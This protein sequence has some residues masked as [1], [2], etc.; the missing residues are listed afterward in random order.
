MNKKVLAVDD[1]LVN[2]KLLERI[3]KDYTVYIETNSLAVPFLMEE[4]DPD[5]VL[6]DTQMPVLNGYTLAKLIKDSSFTKPI[7]FISAEYE[8][9]DIIRGFDSGGDDFLVKPIKMV[10]ISNRIA[11]Q[12]QIYELLESLADEDKDYVKKEIKIRYKEL[13]DSFRSQSE[14]DFDFNSELNLF[15]NSL[16]IFLKDSINRFAKG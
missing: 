16:L 8:T 6:I 13:I 3:L 7:I 4:F 9:E 10:E 14:K 2:L 15:S 1:D 11:N 5:I 12:L